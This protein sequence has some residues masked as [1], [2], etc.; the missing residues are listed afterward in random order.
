MAIVI[1]DVTAELLVLTIDN[2]GNMYFGDGT[3]IDM[4]T[5]G[6]Y[7]IIDNQGH[8]VHG[9]GT[10][11]LAFTTGAGTLG[12]QG[13][14]LSSTVTISTMAGVQPTLQVDSPYPCHSVYNFEIESEDYTQNSPQCAISVEALGLGSFTLTCFEVGQ[15]IGKY[16]G[17]NTMPGG[18][19][20]YSYRWL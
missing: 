1:T 12:Y 6:G 13:S 17:G 9:V 15:N 8:I 19:P 7:G 16:P 5:L 20:N 4:L 11:N 14:T 10:P 18:N 3:P 2:S